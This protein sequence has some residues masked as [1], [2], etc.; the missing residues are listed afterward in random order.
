MMMFTTTEG[1]TELTEFT[2]SKRVGVLAVAYNTC[3]K[4]VRSKIKAPFRDTMA[5]IDGNQCNLGVAEL[6]L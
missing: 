3:S 5:F 6:I 4:Y 1:W 2:A